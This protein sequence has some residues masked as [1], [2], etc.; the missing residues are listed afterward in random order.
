MGLFYARIF[1]PVDDL[2]NGVGEALSAEQALAAAGTL[3]AHVTRIS[4]SP[5]AGDY[6]R[7]DPVL[8]E[9]P[10]VGGAGEYFDS[11]GGF[12]QN[13]IPSYGGGGRITHEDFT[14]AANPAAGSEPGSFI[15]EYEALA[16]SA[17]SYTDSPNVLQYVV[18]EG[19]A[20]IIFYHSKGFLYLENVRVWEDGPR[21]S[22]PAFWTDFRKCKE[23]A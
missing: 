4:Y 17:F 13:F 9:G 2:S 19:Y 1:R 15:V 12:R 14:F 3:L 5:P 18:G 22:T 23:V 21:P 7:I 10:L 20:A 11:S 8:I 6:S 16:E